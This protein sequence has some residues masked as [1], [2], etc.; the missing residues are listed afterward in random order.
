MFLQLRPILTVIVW[1]SMFLMACAGTP[2]APPQTAPAAAKAT[3]A[4]TQPEKTD[5][6]AFYYEENAQFELVSPQGIRVL[7]DVGSRSKLSAPPT[8]TDILLTT[9]SHNDHFDIN[10][11]NMFPGQQLNQ[12][13]GVL[14]VADVKIK[15]IK[16]A[17]N[18]DTP[19]GDNYIF[20][21]EMGGLRIG[22]FGDCGQSKLTQTQLDQIGQLDVMITQL[23]NSYSGVSLEN[24]KAFILIKKLNP[25]L[26]IPTHG[27]ESPDVIESAINKWPK[28][29]VAT[30]KILISPS[31]LTESTQLLVL[32][33]SIT[34]TAYKKMYQM[35]E[36]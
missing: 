15:G 1:G 29:Y 13:E 8:S 30:G 23:Q 28:A 33:D 17:H 16:S 4:P 26:V 21:I 27:N 14:E 10:F 7:I 22:H 24:R 6:V 11:A 19:K 36:W 3:A 9:H 32:G 18:G 2:A 35:A 12:K 20:V 34:E 5:A 31:R 25:K